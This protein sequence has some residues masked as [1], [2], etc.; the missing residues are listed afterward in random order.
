MEL[1]GR[2]GVAL[3]VLVLALAGCGPRV[4]GVPVAATSLPPPKPTAERVL[5]DLTTI[6]PCGFADPSV[7][8]SFGTAE[9]AVPESLDYCTISVRPRGGAE[10]HIDIGELSHVQDEP[11]VVMKHVKEFDDGRYI[12]ERDSGPGFCTRALVFTDQIMLTVDS[13]L[14]QGTP[15][16]TCGMVAAAMDKVIETLAAG[17]VKHRTPAGDSL[18]KLDACKLVSDGTLATQPEFAAA[19]KHD[20]PAHHQC[21]WE[22]GA[23]TLQYTLRLTF[24]AGPPPAPTATNKASTIG[25]HTTVVTRDPHIG[26]S[27]F[28]GVDTGLI[29]FSYPGTAKA[30]ETAS[31]WAKTPVG[32]MADGC[33]AAN[34]IAAEVWPRLPAS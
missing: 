20:Y 4:A 21:Y 34:A 23:S 12:A 18:V 24:G 32:R 30:V 27:D 31:V 7:L 9:F 19:E 17:G 10:V 13:V 33:R 25:G 11:D 26:D 1:A 6:D 29:D 15:P 28:C 8:K 3:A 2:R 22:A 5:G 16:E 14:Y